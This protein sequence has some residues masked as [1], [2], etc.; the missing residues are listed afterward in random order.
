MCGSGIFIQTTR[1][2][3]SASNRVANRLI[4]KRGGVSVLG[5]SK[6]KISRKAARVVSLGDTTAT[7]ASKPWCASFS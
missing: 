1:V 7:L 3:C 6:V 4:L 2:G 5:S